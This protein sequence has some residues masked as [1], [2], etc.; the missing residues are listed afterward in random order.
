MKNEEEVTKL[1]KAIMQ[2]ASDAAYKKTDFLKREKKHEHFE[3]ADNFNVKL[4]GDIAIVSYSSVVIGK[5]YSEHKFTADCEKTFADI[6]KYIKAEVKKCCKKNVTFKELEKG[7]DLESVT[8][9]NMNKQI[10]NYRKSYRI[11]Q[12]KELVLNDEKEE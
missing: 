10:R 12:L 2:A 3:I 9:L 1:M 7:L 8:Q 11:S 4:S 5:L 6:V